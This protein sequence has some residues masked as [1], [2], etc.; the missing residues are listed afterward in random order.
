V[1]GHRPTDDAQAA[2][3]RPAPPGPVFAQVEP[4]GDCNLRCPMCLLSL[5]PRSEEGAARLPFDRFLSYLDQLPT[6]EELHLQGLGE[7]LLHPELCDMVEEGRRRGLTVT[8]NT[9]LSR[10]RAGQAERLAAALDTIHVSIDSADPALYEQ[11]RPGARFEV[12]RE[13][14]VLLDR[15]RRAS[16]RACRLVVV[17]VLL[18]RTLGG[19]DDLV[20]F[21]A[22]AG[23]DAVF[24]QHLFR[25]PGEQDHLP[26]FAPLAAFVDRETLVGAASEEL[27]GPF[28]AAR[29]RAAD[30]GLE[31]RLPSL[32]SLVRA[33][34]VAAHGDHD[35]GPDGHSAR[36]ASATPACDWPWRGVYLTYRGEVL[37]C[38]MAGLPEAACMG[39]LEREP[40]ESVWRGAAYRS[41]RM[42]LAAG[43]APPVCVGCALRAHTF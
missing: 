29:S 15:A 18:R 16:G 21:A 10:L 42:E 27:S 19:L 37:P 33:E 13:N 20:R 4:V 6:I 17:A 43:Q 23:A 1:S 30:L 14:L 8:L 35:G 24:V 11:I 28:A 5:R 41:F 9:N 2:D 32:E 39:E 36:S 31:L 26:F 38:C 22:A 7:P 34:A 40:F 3:S 12:L 25:T